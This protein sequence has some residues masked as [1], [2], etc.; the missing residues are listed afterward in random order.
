MAFL[1]KPL[2]AALSFACLAASPVYADDTVPDGPV[3]ERELGRRPLALNNND[4]AIG[5]DGAGTI[6]QRPLVLRWHRHR[7]A[8]YRVRITRDG[9]EVVN[10][11]VNKP[12]FIAEGLDF[13][14]YKW[15]YTALKNGTALPEDVTSSEQTLVLSKVSV[16]AAA[17]AA[18]AS[19]HYTGPTPDAPAYDVYDQQTGIAEL[20]ARTLA[21]PHPRA[22]PGGAAHSAWIQSLQQRG[23]VNDLINEAVT[24]LVVPDFM[25]ASLVELTDKQSRTLNNTFFPRLSKQA[26]ALVALRQLRPDIYA[27]N[28]ANHL[29]LVREIA[30]WSTAA[31]SPTSHAKQDQINR[32]IAFIL[33]TTYDWF[34]AELD[35]AQQAALLQNIDVR[36]V[37]LKNDTLTLDGWLFGSH[38]WASA[39]FAATIGALVG[40]TG[41]QSPAGA[42]ADRWLSVTLPGYLAAIS[43]WGGEDGGFGNGMGYLANAL[44]SMIPLWDMLKQATGVDLYKTAWAR[45]TGKLLAYM[46]PPGATEVLFGDQ[47]GEGVAREVVV[48][49]AAR[50]QVPEVKWLAQAYLA[51]DYD[52]GR[53]GIMKSDHMISA[54]PAPDLIAQA[55]KQDVSLQFEHSPRLQV[56]DHYWNRSTGWVALYNSIRLPAAR[57]TAI[58]FKSSPFGS[59]NHSHADQN[60]FLLYHRGEAMAVDSGVFDGF[61]SQYP[62]FM[63]WYIHT[64]A[65]N[66][67]TYDGTDDYGGLGQFNDVLRQDP[68]SNLYYLNFSSGAI[69]AAP[70]GDANQDFEIV[71][72][73]ALPA[74]ANQDSNFRIAL[75]GLVYHRPSNTVLVLDRMFV[76]PAAP[77]YW[78]WNLHTPT[79]M[80]VD[81]LKPTHGRWEKGAA[82]VCLQHIFPAERALTFSQQQGYPVPPGEGKTVRENWHQKWRIAKRAAIFEQATVLVPDCTEPA[83]SIR[84]LDDGRYDYTVNGQTVRINLKQYANY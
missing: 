31:G 64:R 35:S 65:H 49:W 83:V 50:T 21:K 52:A 36:L 32:Q 73:D 27:A 80:Q 18:N 46:T 60:S 75:R 58:Y 8:F 66:A 51:E 37:G 68:V 59:F 74:Y 25:N 1:R 56:R 38:G 5:E 42:P 40:S 16:A 41:P 33:A 57:R 84:R 48:G 22:L 13:G 72:G 10:K 20:V 55:F 82:S 63:Q 19:G 39:S 6:T 14:T 54:N 76:N 23:L 81:P 26:V 62:H 67:I 34:F 28:L 45:N 69:K 71:V 7:T 61:G 30:S 24:P 9:Q 12:W 77:R 17:E 53:T 47:G 3:T 2:C 15:T 43:P 44:D 78:E 4:V 29:N 79:Q 11:V 70:Q